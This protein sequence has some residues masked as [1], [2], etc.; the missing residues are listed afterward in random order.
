VSTPAPLRVT[1]VNAGIL[2]MQSFSQ[3]LREAMAEEPAVAA[4]HVVLSEDLTIPDRLIRRALCVPLW[5]DGL[6]GLRNVDL[7]RF[8]REYHAGLLAA[9]RLGRLDDPD[10]LHFHRQPTAFASLARMRRIPSVV[11]IDSTQDIMI[12]A[13][14]TRIERATYLANARRAG[15]VFRAAAAIVSTSAWAAGCLRARYP[16]CR[17]PI[18]VMPPPVRL[19]FFDPA[20]IAE[21][22]ARAGRGPVRVLFVGGDFVRKGGD[23]LLAVWRDAGF[24]RAATLD[25]VTSAAPP[26]EGLAGVR[27]HR[28]VRAYTPEWVDLWRTADVFVMPTRHEA[29]GTAF[30]E[31]AAAGLPRIGTRITAVPETIDDGRSGLLVA[32]GD[33]VALRAALERLIADADLRQAYGEAGRAGV[34]RTAH[35]VAYRERLVGII[36]QAASDGPPGRR[37]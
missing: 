13:A 31:A 24:G 17:T 16:D 21:R 23:D 2:G 30:Q 19:G 27:L 29:F 6:F 4:T 15:A 10:V 14:R 37:R 33:R 22:R 5:P 18:T 12:D 34:E 26:L 36:R 32:P 25:L 8:R 9:R 3:Y 20:W 7:A 35:P 1:F 11:S 28:S